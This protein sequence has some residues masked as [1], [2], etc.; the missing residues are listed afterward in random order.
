MSSDQNKA[1]PERE[2]VP[3]HGVGGEA[4]PIYKGKLGMGCDVNRRD[5][6]KA[7]HS[8]TGNGKCQGQR[9]PVVVTGQ[10]MGLWSRESEGE[11]RG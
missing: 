6:I 4:F 5:R 11:S 9:V 3:G 7:E 1:G 2:G 10:Q 8:K